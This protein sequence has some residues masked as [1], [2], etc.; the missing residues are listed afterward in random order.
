MT[1]LHVF[2]LLLF[3]MEKKTFSLRWYKNIYYFKFGLENEKPPY[4]LLN[5]NLMYR[6]QAAS[7]LFCEKSLFFFARNISCRK[8]IFPPS[9]LFF[10][11]FC[12]FHIISLLCFLLIYIKHFLKGNTVVQSFVSYDGKIYR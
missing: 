10:F 2:S 4:F 11:L 5:H 3:F 1:I 7:S 12:S 9:F 8:N 6:I